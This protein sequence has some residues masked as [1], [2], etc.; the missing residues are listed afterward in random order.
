MRTVDVGVQQSH[1]D[2]TDPAFGDRRCRALHARR[3]ERDEDAA[4]RS[5]AFTHDEPVF[6]ARERLGAGNGEVVDRTTILAS[7]LEHVA[8]A[9]GR[10]ERD[11]R[12]FEMHLPEQ[13]IRCDGAGVRDDGEFIG[14]HLREQRVE[15]REQTIFRGAGRRGHLVTN[16]AAVAGK[17][18]EVGERAAD[19]D[20]DPPAHAAPSPRNASCTSGSPI[21]SAAAPSK[22]TRPVCKT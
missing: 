2:G 3:V 6:T 9:F 1:R 16:D 14:R 15:R 19:V 21:K 5:A 4:V 22:T 13:S 7:D 12:Q 18:H 8:K 10:H 20:A 11:A 17:R